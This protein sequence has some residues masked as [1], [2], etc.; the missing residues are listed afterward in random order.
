MNILIL[1]NSGFE[2]GS[3]GWDHVRPMKM[4]QKLQ[5]CLERCIAIMRE[6]N[7]QKAVGYRAPCFSLDRER[8][9][10]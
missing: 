10:G 5:S 1:A 8:L 4:I 2:I 9:D 6:I 7:E 3:H